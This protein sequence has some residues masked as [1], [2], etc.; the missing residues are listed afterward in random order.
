MTPQIARVRHSCSASLVD[1]DCPL[2]CAAFVLSL[3]ILLP[4]GIAQWIFSK[5]RIIDLA[6]LLNVVLQ[7]KL[8]SF[9]TSFVKECVIVLASVLWE[10]CMDFEGSSV[11]QSK[12]LVVASGTLLLL[13]LHCCCHC[14]VHF[15]KRMYLLVE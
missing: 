2:R 13:H 8:S 12:I 9:R 4:V 6:C 1:T 10:C 11:F 3:C 7:Q 5:E 15:F 14:T